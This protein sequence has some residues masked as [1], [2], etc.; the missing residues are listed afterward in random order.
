MNEIVGENCINWA[1]V[2]QPHDCTSFV[3]DE[4]MFIQL[5]NF[6]QSQRLS[7][8]VFFAHPSRD[9]FFHSWTYLAHPTTSFK[10]TFPPTPFLYLCQGFF[11][12]FFSYHCHYCNGAIADVQRRTRNCCKKTP[13]QVRLLHLFL[14]YQVFLH[15]QFGFR[16]MRPLFCLLSKFINEAKENLLE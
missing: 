14:H 3:L 12:I 5:L 11:S 10:K 2:T 1:L 7:H 6:V 13:K 15:F 8:N 9:F 16:F 4:L